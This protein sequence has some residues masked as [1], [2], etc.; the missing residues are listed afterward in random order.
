MS[1]IEKLADWPFQN[2]WKTSLATVALLYLSPLQ[3]D[4]LFYITKK[5]SIGFDPD[6]PPELSVGLFIT[7]AYW[8][9]FLQ[10]VSRPRIKT[11]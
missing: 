2:K 1:L 5:G 11:H 10:K 7:T 3:R 4:P 8:L 9:S 6:V